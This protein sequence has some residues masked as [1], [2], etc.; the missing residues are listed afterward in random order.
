MS[1]PDWRNEVASFELRN[2]PGLTKMIIMSWYHLRMRVGQRLQR[3]RN[4]H[5]GK[6]YWLPWE[7][8]DLAGLQSRIVG[9]QRL[10]DEDTYEC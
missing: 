4:H 2:P 5:L 3:S 7:G 8:F 6:N 9:E 1:R 10:V